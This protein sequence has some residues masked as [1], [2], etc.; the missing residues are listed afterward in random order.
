MRPKEKVNH[1][2]CDRMQLSTFLQ[3]KRKETKEG[4]HSPCVS[5][6]YNLIE[7]SFS[8]C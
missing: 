3:R 4:A 1:S 7:A 8:V 5:Q 6:F 2:V